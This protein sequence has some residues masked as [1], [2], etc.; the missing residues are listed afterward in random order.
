MYRC[1]HT[2]IYIHSHM[3]SCGT[4]QRSPRWFIKSS[5]A[6]CTHS[7]LHTHA[8]HCRYTYIGIRIHIYIHIYVY[9]WYHKSQSALIRP[10]LQHDTHPLKPVHTI[11]LVW[12]DP[13]ICMTWF[14]HMCDVTHSHAW[15]VWLNIAYCHTKS[16]CMHLRTCY[17]RH[18]PQP[19]LL[20]VLYIH[21]HISVYI[22]V[23]IHI[24]TYVYINI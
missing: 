6:T 7:H 5:Y 17:T 11:S 16:E 19:T 3:Y 9:L 12:R 23:C 22:H 21:I 13:S 2:D 20:Y 18:S 8:Y 24:L 4:T 1:I 10:I 15:Q 14:M